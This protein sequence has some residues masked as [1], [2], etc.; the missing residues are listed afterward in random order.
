MCPFGKINDLVCFKTLILY[1][2]LCPFGNI[3]SLVLTLLSNSYK[4]TDLKIRII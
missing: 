3:I 1:Q 2:S 4:V